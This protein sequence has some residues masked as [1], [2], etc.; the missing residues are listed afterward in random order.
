MKY[1]KLNSLVG[2]GHGIDQTQALAETMA[3]EIELAQ[4]GVIDASMG[5][6]KDII[7]G[8]NR[9]TRYEERRRARIKY[10]ILPG[11]KAGFPGTQARHEPPLGRFGGFLLLAAL[12]HRSLH[13]L[14]GVSSP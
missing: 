4:S 11:L 7:N 14:A 1:N 2:N 10:D 6:V 9:Q 3:K 12:P 5:R 8:N 13:R